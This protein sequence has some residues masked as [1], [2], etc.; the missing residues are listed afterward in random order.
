MIFSTEDTEGTEKMEKNQNNRTERL[1]I[2]SD[3]AVVGNSDTLIIPYV[4]CVPW[5]K[6]QGGK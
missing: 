4:P 5:I 6:D 2:N 3:H 1:K